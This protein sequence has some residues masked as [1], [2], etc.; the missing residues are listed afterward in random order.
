FP[1]SMSA[2]T[3]EKVNSARSSVLFVI[4]PISTKSTPETEDQEERKKGGCCKC[5]RK[6]LL[7]ILTLIAVVTGLGTGYLLKD[8]TFTPVTLRFIALPGE[9]LMSMFKG[10]VVPLIV[11]S[12]VAGIANMNAGSM[13]KLNGLAFAYYFFTTLVAVAVG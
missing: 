9:I 6:N 1:T 11:V 10:I 7:L 4:Y 12:I 3:S 5:L 13:G 8:T 2:S